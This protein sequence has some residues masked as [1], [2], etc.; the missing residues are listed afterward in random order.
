MN[1]LSKFI[2]ISLTAQE[3]TNLTLAV[4]ELVDS[5]FLVLPGSESTIP[6]ITDYIYFSQL[7]PFRE[8]KYKS[9]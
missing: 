5:R 8:F 3:L 2:G 1:C 9:E 4:H 6:E 7:K